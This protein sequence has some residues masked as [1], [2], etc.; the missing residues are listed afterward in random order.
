MKSMET[1]HGKHVLKQFIYISLLLLLHKATQLNNII[2][3]C[4]TCYLFLSAILR[5]GMPPVGLKPIPAYV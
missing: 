2:L 1:Y 4:V 3:F 5:Q